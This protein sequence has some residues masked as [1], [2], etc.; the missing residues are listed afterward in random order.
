VRYRPWEIR[1]SFLIEQLARLR[2]G[3][4]QRRRKGEAEC[5]EWRVNFPQMKVKG[6]CQRAFGK[7]TASEI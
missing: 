7:Y 5:E 1:L 2:I 4:L 6:K 3:A